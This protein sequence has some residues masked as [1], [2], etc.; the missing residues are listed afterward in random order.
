M[1]KNT[2]LTRQDRVAAQKRNQDTNL[3]SRLS[4]ATANSRAHAHKCL[5]TSGSLS[6]VEWRV[7]WDLNEAGPLTVRDIAAIQRCDHSLV[8]RALP[9]MQAKGFV[10]LSQDTTDKRQTLVALTPTG[11]AAF[12][13]AAPAMKARRDNIKAA[14]TAEE[15]A[16]FL[17][18]IERFEKTLTAPACIS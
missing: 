18:F 9:Q 17:E 11:H 10:D 4:A 15:L 14:F 7:L 8:S 3:F 16:I 13:Q 12:D 2:R 1:T 6:V 5:K